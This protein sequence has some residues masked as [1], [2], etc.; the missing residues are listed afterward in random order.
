MNKDDCD[1]SLIVQSPLSP[2][3]LMPIR[4]C[5][6]EKKRGKLVWIQLVVYRLLSSRNAT[7]AIAAMMSTVETVKYVSTGAC[8]TGVGTGVGCGAS[9]TYTA[10]S[11]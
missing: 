10:V 8:G 6:P 7:M 2:C 5:D 9:S 1:S 3:L 11:A 4:F